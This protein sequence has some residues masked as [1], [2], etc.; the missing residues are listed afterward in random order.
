M[1]KSGITGN[2]SGTNDIND[3]TN[4]PVLQ[5]YFDPMRMKT[6]IRQDLQHNTPGLFVTPLVLLLDN[7]DDTPWL[8]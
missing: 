4:R 1:S 7:I 2:R 3:P 5:T 6:G 8:N